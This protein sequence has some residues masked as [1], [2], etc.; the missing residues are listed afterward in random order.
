MAR[1]NSL[2][3]DSTDGLADAKLVRHG[4]NTTFGDDSTLVW[5]FISRSA[6]KK[7]LQHAAMG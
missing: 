6:L 5:T 7:L 1:S 3:S 2:L 4:P